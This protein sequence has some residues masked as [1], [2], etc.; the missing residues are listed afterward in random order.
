VKV[1]CLYASALGER[2]SEQQSAVIHPAHPAI[3]PPT[4]P[5]TILSQLLHS[6]QPRQDGAALPQGLAH[7]AAQ[8]APPKCCLQG[9]QR[10]CKQYKLGHCACKPSSSI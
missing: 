9:Q 1:R 3:H 4:S 8:Q 5:P 10:Q 6:I 2:G 7:P